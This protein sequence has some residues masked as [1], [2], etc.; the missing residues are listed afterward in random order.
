MLTGRGTVT[1]RELRVEV[2]YLFMKQRIEIG[3]FSKDTV[4]LLF[5]RPYEA[6]TQLI[7]KIHMVFMAATKPVRPG[8]KFKQKHKINKKEC[9]LNLAIA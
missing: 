5:E 4:F 1:M 8:R 9:Y 7:Q 6:I 3:N 2:D